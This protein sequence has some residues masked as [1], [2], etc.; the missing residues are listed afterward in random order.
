MSHLPSHFWYLITNFG[1]AGLTLPLAFAIALWLAV[2]Y[3]WRLAAGWLFLL[4][5]A[6]AFVTATKIAFLGW[7]IG[8]RVWDFTGLSG[9]SMFATAVFPVAAFLVLLSAPPAVRV[10]GVVLALLGGATVGLSRVVIEAHSPSEAITG[11]LVGALAALVFVRIAWNATPPGRLPVAPV[12]VSL[13]VLTL[14]LHKLHLPTQRWVTHIALK[15]SGH[16]RP[17]VRARWKGL[18]DIESPASPASP[19]SPVA[20]LQKTR[21]VALPLP[22]SDA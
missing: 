2:G 18:R 9:H 5:V 12:V 21:N 7:G 3:S 19:A 6:I 8:V 4:G 13:M 1:G 17:F 11:C 10:A 15:V 22:D 14:G 20:P 16:D